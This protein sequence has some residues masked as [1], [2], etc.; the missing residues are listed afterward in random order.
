MSVGLVIVELT[1]PRPGRE[2]TQKVF[3]THL[4]RY[5]SDMQLRMSFFE[6]LVILSVVFHPSFSFSQGFVDDETLEENFS[7]EKE[8]PEVEK[9][10]VSAEEDVIIEESPQVKARK[11][12][13]CSYASNVSYTQ[14]RESVGGYAGVQAGSYFPETYQPDFS[15]STFEEYYGKDGILIEVVM[16]IKWNFALGS[17][18]AQVSGGFY[19][20][21]NDSAEATLD[22]YPITYGAMYALD[23]LFS[24]PYIVPYG[25]AGGY[26]TIYE[27]QAGAF[28]VRGSTGIAPVFAGGLMFQLDWLDKDSADS[29]YLDY[30]LENTFLYLEVRKFLESTNPFPDFS[31]GFHFNG[32]MKVEF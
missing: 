4:V 18:A 10:G 2:L 17:L 25:F 21:T 8:N 19:K 16:G 22:V 26:T 32:G 29:G 30:G 28:S 1:S 13:K 3:P 15:T 31:T 5:N 6:T 9:E 7:E 20:V 14:R 24:E 27:E 11:I 12:C 23:N